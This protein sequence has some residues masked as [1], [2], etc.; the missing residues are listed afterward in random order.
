[1]ELKE[2]I[3]SFLNYLEQNKEKPAVMADLRCALIPSREFRSWPHIAGCGF[4]LGSDRERAA[5]LV[6]AF[7]FGCQPQTPEDKKENMGDV[8]RKIAC[9]DNGKDGLA[10][11]ALRFKRILDCETP[12]E[13][14][15]HLKGILLLTKTKGIPVNHANLFRDVFNWDRDNGVK[16]GWAGHY[17]ASAKKK[18][19][20]DGKT[21]E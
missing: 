6:T 4:D 10:T 18:D 3:S 5:A 8:L 7:A 14:A 19:E 11:F 15:L 20:A 2:K 13:L 1:M 9:G 12:Q 21:G 16:Y 17:Y